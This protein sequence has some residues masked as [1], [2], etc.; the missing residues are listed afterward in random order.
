VTVEPW[1]VQMR[2]IGLTRRL[3][4]SVPHAQPDPQFPLPFVL[5]SNISLLHQMR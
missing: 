3:S 4:L 5:L 1:C 2:A